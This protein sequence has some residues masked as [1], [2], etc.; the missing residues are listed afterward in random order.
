M[1]KVTY[2]IVPHDGGFAYT[3]DGDFSE[4]YPAKAEAVAA[5]R[6]AAGAAAAPPVSAAASAV[7]ARVTPGWPMK[8]G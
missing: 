5:A 3:L 1:R 7:P 4:P 6:R 8:P 2:R